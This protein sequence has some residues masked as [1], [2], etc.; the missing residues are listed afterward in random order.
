MRLR[1]LIALSLLIPLIAPSVAAAAPKSR[2]VC[3]TAFDSEYFYLAAV[4][5]K[6]TIQASQ[7]AI[8]ADL[9][10]DD[11][12]VVALDLDAGSGATRRSARS[13]TMVVS[14]AGG[15]QLYRGADARPLSGFQDFLP[16][17]DGIR[18]PFKFGVAQRP[19]VSGGLRS[20][21]VE[22]AIP[23]VE[24]GGPPITGSRG[25]IN[26]AALS[27]AP[28]TRRWLS[29]G[30]ATEDSEQ[31]SNPSKWVDITFV[32][33]PTR[34]ALGPNTVVICARVQTAKPIVNGEIADAE[35]YNLTS[36]GFEESEGGATEAVLPAAIAART[37]PRIPLTKARPPAPM[38]AR[39]PLTEPAPLKPQPLPRLTMALYRYDFQADPR[40]PLPP[41]PL[42]RADGRPLLAVTPAEGAGP[43]LTYDRVDWHIANL[44]GMREA[45]I[46]VALPIFRAGSDS[47]STYA[48]RGLAA[49]ATALRTLRSQGRDYPLVG[50]YLDTSSLHSDD[51]LPLD[52]TRTD[53]KETLYSAIRTFF[54]SVPR[55]YRLALPLSEENGGGG[56]NLV[57]LS[58][59]EP[60]ANVDPSLVR[61]LRARHM[62]EFGQS[63]IVIG[64]SAFSEACPLDGM[65]PMTGAAGTE[66]GPKGWATCAMVRMAP[67]GP[68]PGESAQ[69]AAKM[70]STEAYRAALRS[71]SASSADWLVLD[72]WNDY[73]SARSIAPNLQDGRIF[74]DITRSA[75]LQWL[76][77]TASRVAALAHNL[78]TSVTAGSTWQVSL[79]LSNLGG[80][81]WSP[82]THGIVYHWKP[83]TGGS[84]TSEVVPMPAALPPGRNMHVDI[85]LKCPSQAGEYMLVV[86]VAE[87]TQ[88]GKVATSLASLG[89]LAIAQ[90]VRVYGADSPLYAAT[91]IGHDLPNVAESG[92]VYTASVTLRN[93][94]TLP[95]RKDSDAR[96]IVRLEPFLGED[97]TNPHPREPLL[98]DAS[99]PL[100]VDVAPGQAV[101][102]AMP[103]AFASV[104]GSPIPPT[105]SSGGLPY[106]LRYEI[107]PDA[108]GGSG[109][110][111]ESEPMVLAELEP[112]AFFTR[113]QSPRQMPAERRI[114][115]PVTLRNPTSQT[116]KKDLV[117]VGYHWYYQDGT[118]LT[119]EDE[120]TALPR[121]MPPGGEEN[122]LAW[123]TPPRNDG[124]YWLVWDLKIGDTWASTL[125][126][127]RSGETRVLPVEIVQGK[128]RFVDLRGAYNLDGIAGREA[129]GDGDFSGSGGNL[130]AELTP[131]YAETPIASSGLGSP[132]TGGA[133]E[134]ERRFS[135]RWGSKVPGERNMIKC[136]GQR[137]ALVADPKRAEVYSAV[138]IIAY[139]TKPDQVA[140]LTF[141][142]A[143]GAEQLTAVPI[144]EWDKPA[145]FGEAVAYRF[146]FT[147]QK[148]EPSGP[149]ASLYRYTIRIRENQKLVSL[150]LPRA[151]DV[152]IVAI[153]LER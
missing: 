4:V 96:I 79:R 39:A 122:V 48:L 2:V 143:N 19:A 76:G 9:F 73:V 27:A 149:P 88:G 25:R 103:L 80:S 141:T 119:W 46:D 151:P 45:G 106:A 42:R 82:Q 148:S 6:P 139:A 100:P 128:L 137:V 92:G 17:P 56:A 23:W 20:Y 67:S 13:A 87:M 127:A 138:H 114:P 10:T 16:G 37:R 133:L 91:L 60:F 8:F 63:L 142:F 110:A 129:P 78:P 3:Y 105:A 99:A 121:D 38:P 62:Q 152:R 24:L 104:D 21:T 77:G 70:L 93:D 55:W 145:R 130:P 132:Q 33:A 34:A 86:D 98:A 31:T 115:V 1:A 134:S 30:S 28:D 71:V 7:R 59:R 64:D 125:A 65:L 136:D 5:Q 36:F 89:G 54:R 50:M 97:T 144:S 11:C 94:G 150:T 135:F 116:W 126:S 35:W 26:V 68:T 118:E 140:N 43:W 102:V 123:L 95:W 29:L 32:D 117:R 146:P 83:R 18:M 44:A 111:T 81:A 22:L 90:P 147:Y 53:R 15:A 72:S 120:T 112:G 66:T 101:T 84:E 41:T 47:G 131:P 40:K 74:V 69:A 61:Y 52:L 12:L 75:T 109:G 57:V 51:G 107:S 85:S 49:M 113:D 124:R 108:G 14:A 153:T 58:S